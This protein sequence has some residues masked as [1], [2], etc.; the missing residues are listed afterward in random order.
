[1][2]KPPLKPLVS[3][4]CFGLPALLFLTVCAFMGFA[5]FGDSS[6]LI[7]D[8]SDQ[9]V[10]FLCALKHGDMYFSWNTALGGSYIGTFSYYV[11][12]PFSLL[13]LLCPD[14][15]MAI[16]VVF[17]VALKLGL[18]GFTFS[19]LL[20]RRS[21]R[22]DL[23]TLAFALC[24]AL[25]AY[26]MA[27]AMSFMWLDGVLW[28]PVLLMGVEDLLDG[29]RPWVLLFGLVSSF[30]STWYIS[31][32]T[33]IFCAVYLLW[34][35]ICEG[36]SPIKRIIRLAGWAGLALLLS[37]WLWL[38]TAMSMLDGKL[39]D[40]SAPLTIGFNWPLTTLFYK[41][42][43]P[44]AYDSVTYT[45]SAFLYCSLPAVILAALWFFLPDLS[46]RA[47]VATLGFGGF[48][49]LCLW[50]APLDRVWHLFQ[51]PNSFPGR[52][53]FVVSCF[54]LLLGYDA[55]L[56]VL[57]LIKSV[58]LSKFLPV[59]LAL[60]LAVDMSANALLI[61]RGLDK[62]LHFESYYSYLAYKTEMDKLLENV[63]AI[64][65]FQRI[66]NDDHRS[67]NEP[68]AY[69]YKGLTFF[70]SSYNARVN[71]LLN[72][73]GYAQ[74]W[75]WCTS[76]CGSPVADALMG[77]GWRM[78]GNGIALP[79]MY[80]HLGNGLHRGF[81][82]AAPGYFT[83]CGPSDTDGLNWPE[84]NPF[85]YQNQL[86]KLVGGWD[87]EMFT[88]LSSIRRVNEGSRVQFHFLSDGQPVYAYFDGE[89]DD[90][91][92]ATDRALCTERT[93]GLQYLGTFP[94]GTE[95]ELL[96]YCSEPVTDP[97]QLKEPLLYALNTENLQR[98]LDTLKENRL[99]VTDHG[100]GWLVGAVNAFRDGNIF[101]S[102]PAI[103]GWTV[104]VDGEP[105]ECG[106]FRDTLL[107]I[108]VAA[109]THTISMH[110]T[111]P[112]LIAGLML[113]GLGVMLTLALLLQKR[114]K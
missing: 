29:K 88:P 91:V 21:G 32:M 85:E 39:A 1:M 42:L 78:G 15:H 111:P 23:T 61:F 80:E 30:V 98:M 83:A 79:A 48:L 114:K 6:I 27:Y 16:A 10:E 37:A 31:Y 101:T 14:E 76:Q 8:L 7:F 96:V 25:M 44:G 104:K 110:Y 112:G 90:P 95:H 69:G 57:G 19:L 41:L 63:H 105:V 24:Y 97:A 106:T 102:I 64:G 34:R 12:S 100:N 17:L 81:E 28:L 51:P 13:T 89:L 20:R 108:P 77:I 87:L 4:C 55:L 49:L 54:I 72:D 68:A 60:V 11:S 67:R 40:A 52:W 22:Y 58:R 73:L 82:F 75:F 9:F 99:H 103:P 56:W 66:A 84:D 47:K 70:S 46:R 74:D 33:G 45:G 35:C 26:N 36:R 18:A 93:N 65:D 2:K 109:G 50:F 71:E 43:V 86:M 62:E 3:L 113:T 53:S 5:P 94:E 38:P 92:W 59:L 107:T